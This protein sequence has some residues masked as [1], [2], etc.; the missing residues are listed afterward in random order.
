M[1]PKTRGSGKK[2]VVQQKRHVIECFGY[3]E[4]K[5]VNDTDFDINYKY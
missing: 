3:F 2:T 1:Q 5:I 4:K